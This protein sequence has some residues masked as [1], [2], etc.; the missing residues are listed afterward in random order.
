MAEFELDH[1]DKDGG[2]WFATL[3]AFAQGYV[4]ALF[5]TEANPD[6]EE[7][8]DKT[9]LDLSF[10]ARERIT[11]DCQRFQET[12]TTLLDE[13]YDQLKNNYDSTQAGRDFWFTRNGDG[14]GY[15]DRDLGDIGEALSGA[16]QAFGGVWVYAGDDGQLYF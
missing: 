15:W 5:F 2:Q 7:M 16:A 10:E 4:E 1:G 6:N 11:Q 9:V 13:A 8:R 3:D 14:V 12:N